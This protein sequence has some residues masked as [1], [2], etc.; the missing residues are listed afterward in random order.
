[1][2][3]NGLAARLCL[4]IPDF[5]VL[6]FPTLTLPARGRESRCACGK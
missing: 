1:M 5:C 2:Y 6:K 3:Q 4:L